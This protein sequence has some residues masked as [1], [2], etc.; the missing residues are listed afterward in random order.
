MLK[1]TKANRL[2]MPNIFSGF[3][4]LITG[5][6]NNNYFSNAKL[7]ILTITHPQYIIEHENKMIN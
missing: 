6:P 1:G 4:G 3:S 5:F 2:N 7:K